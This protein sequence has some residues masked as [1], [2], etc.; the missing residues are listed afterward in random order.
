MIREFH[1]RIDS[2][3]FVSGFRFWFNL[4]FR[5]L[6]KMMCI[7]NTMS[8]WS[9]RPSNQFSTKQTYIYNSTCAILAERPDSALTSGITIVN[10]QSKCKSKIWWHIGLNSELHYI[11]ESTMT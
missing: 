7:T 2:R 11:T 5:H 9:F 6:P 3:L 8:D 4:Y 1:V 10:A